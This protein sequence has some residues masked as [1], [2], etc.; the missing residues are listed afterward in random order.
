MQVNTARREQQ[1]ALVGF[2][3]ASGSGKTVSALLVAYGMM[4]EKYK[5][6]EEVNLWEK[7]GVIDT[8][9]K[10]SMLYVGQ[11]F[12]DIEVGGF[13]HIDL[14]PPYTTA[15]YTKAIELLKESGCEVIL[16]DSLSHQ[17]TGEGGL[18]ETHNSM[19]GNSF[20]NWGKLSGETTDLIKALTS[21]DMHF[22]T[23]LRTKTEY[24]VEPN[25][26]GKMAPRKIGTKPVQKDD[27]EYEFIINFH[28]DIDHMAF[29][30]KDNTAL[31]SDAARLLNAESGAQLYRW[32]ELG[33]DVK[34]ELAKEK[35]NKLARLIEL[36]ESSEENAQLVKSFEAS[37]GMTIDNFP[38]RLLD[39]AIERLEQLALPEGDTND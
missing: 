11:T 37:A 39:R 21:N 29:P 34:A 17:W 31:F 27:L 7:I 22:L 6:D 30:T 23:T 2:I 38:I 1:K 28:I 3:G 26:K 5:D 13:S 9:H 12:G 15:R 14:T 25:E 35:E 36:A 10:R 4:Q 24:V 19:T 8:E 20:Q 32:L 16:I 18:I 33:V